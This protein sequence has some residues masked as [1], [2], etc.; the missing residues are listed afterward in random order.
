VPISI[1]NPDVEQ[2]ARAVAAEAGESLTEA[3]RHAL[4]ERLER[5]RGSRRA[6][7]TF[8]SIMEIS[9]RCRA[10]PDRDR[11]SA[12]EVLGYDERGTFG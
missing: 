3:V 10:L 8:E 9:R 5:M 6:P 12:D 4:E 1:K 7:T 2:L 11:R